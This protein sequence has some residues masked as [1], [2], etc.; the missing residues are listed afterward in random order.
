MDGALRNELEKNASSFIPT[1]IVTE[2]VFAAVST[3]T[4]PVTQQANL[5]TLIEPADFPQSI[6]VEHA[7]CRDIDGKARL[8]VQRAIVR[9]LEA[10]F[11]W[12]DMCLSK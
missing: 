4:I 11:A 3:L 12:Q 2:F 8:K 7:L 6:T 10:C 5:E 1:E 9:Y